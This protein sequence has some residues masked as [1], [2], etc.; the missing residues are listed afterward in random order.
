[1]KKFINQIQKTGGLFLLSTFALMSCT[2][3]FQ[4]LNTNPD[5]VTDGMLDYDNLRTGAAITT[6]QLDVIPTSDV[7]ANAYQ[8][9]ENLV[10][11][12]FSGYMAATGQWNGSSNNSTY[13][14][15]FGGWNDVMFTVAFTNVMPSWK[16]ICT[17]ENKE[18]EPIPYA[19]AQV[20]KVATMHRLVD[21]YGPLPYFQFGH[22]GITTPYDSQEEIYASFFTDLTEAIRV[23]ENFCIKNPSSRPLKKYDLV[24]EGDV[25]KWAKFANTLKLRLAMRIVYVDAANARKYA[26]EAVNSEIGVMTNNDDNA[27]LHSANGITVFHPLKVIWYMYKDTRMGASIESYLKGYKDARLDKYFYESEVD[28]GGYHG[29]R[30]GIIINDKSLYEKMSSPRVEADAKVQWMCASEAWFLRAEGALRG[31]NMKGT[32]KDLYETGVRTSFAQWGASIGA[33]LTD[34]TTKPAKFEDVIGSNSIGARSTISPVYNEEASNEEK[35][36][37]IITQKWLSM[38]PEGQE[39][40]SEFRRTGYPKIFPVVLNY[41]NGAIDTEVQIRRLPFPQAEY[42]NNGAEVAKAVSLL[43]GGVDNGG[44]KLWWDKKNK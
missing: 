30:T 26:E 32:E 39:A 24:F 17:E 6:M 44:T 38:Y 14:L 1:M 3:G 23:L 33:Y 2:D 35:L 21:T 37:R 42:D 11:D 36:E 12:I 7:G 28:G 25:R 4:T 22:G 9:A 43:G 13:N 8:R 27:L 16:R 10:G 5:K 15:R 18:K 31:W 20:I 40:W 19:I 34:D 29:V 41:S